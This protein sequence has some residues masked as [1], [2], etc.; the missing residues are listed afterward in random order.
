MQ[1]DWMK[2]YIDFKTDKRKNVKNEFEKCLFKLMNNNA[3]GK[4]M[5]NL[6]KRINVKLVNNA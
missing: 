2:K 5:E 4:T 1:S 3:H 6:R